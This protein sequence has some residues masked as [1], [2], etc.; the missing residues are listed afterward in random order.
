[1]EVMKS[2]AV[3]ITK[4]ILARYIKLILTPLTALPVITCDTKKEFDCGGGMC[5]P[6]TKVCDG[7][8]DCP[9]FQDEPKE[10]CGQDEC[11]VNNGGCSHRCID[12]P[13]GFYCDCPDG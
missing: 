1:M 4:D 3:S 13:A 9:E 8:P 12:T 5:I 11:R 10:K 7:K 2:I 6:L